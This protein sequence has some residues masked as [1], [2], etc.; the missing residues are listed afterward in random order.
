MWWR[1]ATDAGVEDRAC[2]YGTTTC[3]LSLLRTS[4]KLAGNCEAQHDDP[5]EKGKSDHPGGPRSMETSDPWCVFEVSY[6]PVI[7]VSRAG[8]M[9][10]LCVEL[11]GGWHA[12]SGLD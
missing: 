3:L 2:S 7:A 12:G 4:G 9:L 10:V 5:H 11:T 6:H 8:A 1:D